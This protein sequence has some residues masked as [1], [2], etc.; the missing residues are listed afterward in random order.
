MSENKLTNEL[1]ENFKELKKEADRKS[2]WRGRMD[3]VEELGQ[4][5]SQQ[6]VQLL[7]R[8]LATDT[9]F[10]VQE[11][12]YRQL[13][14]LGQDV[15]APQKKVGGPIKDTDK[16]LTRIKKSLPKG[17]TFGEFEEKLKKMRLDLYDTYEGE[18]GKD[19]PAWLEEK[20]ASLPGR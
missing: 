16:I 7:K 5:K 9:V 1:P 17:H 12:A 8:I 4:F 19:F 20:W 6:T 2:N 18:L 3:A 14:Q 13:K 10:K 15:E 11:A